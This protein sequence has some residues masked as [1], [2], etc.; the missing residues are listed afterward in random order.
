MTERLEWNAPG[1][2]RW[3]LDRSHINQPATLIS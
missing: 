1:P 3:A 2:G